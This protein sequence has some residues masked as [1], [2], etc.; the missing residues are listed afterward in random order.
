[1]A[2]LFFL[3]F[4]LKPFAVFAQVS[5]FKNVELETITFG[6]RAS[7]ETLSRES[8]LPKE[9]VSFQSARSTTLSAIGTS[10]LDPLVQFGYPSGATS[11]A[12]GG[13]T[14]DDT[15]VSTLGVPLNLTQG[16]GADLSVLPSYLWSSAEISSTPV[17]QGYTPGAASGA[18]DLKLWTRERVLSGKR[19]R[20]EFD[21]RVTAQYDRQVQTVSVATERPGIA[22]NLGTSLGLQEGPAGSLSYE[23]YEDASQTYR[24]H[25]LGTDQRGASLGSRSNPTPRATKSTWRVIPV[26]ET[27]RRLGEPGHTWLWQSTVFADWNGIR[28]QNPASSGN[29]TSS[30]AFASGIENAISFNSTTIS[31]SLRYE[32]FRLAPN[33]SASAVAAD[34][35][36]FLIGLTQS[37]ELEGGRELKLTG[38]AQGVNTIGVEPALRA[39]LKTHPWTFELGTLAKMPTQSARYYR[40]PGTSPGDPDFFTGN[41]DLKTER[42]WFGIAAHETEAFDSDSQLKSELKLERRERVQITQGAT[43]VNAGGATLGSLE[44]R[45]EIKRWGRFDIHLGL[46][47]NVSRLEQNQN[48]YP[49]LP[50]LA[51]KV[52]VGYQVSSDFA[53]TSRAHYQGP[54][55][56]SG[57][58]FH[59]HYTLIDLEARWAPSTQFNLVG[60]V[61]NITDQRADVVFDFPLPGALA[62]LGVEIQI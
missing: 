31:A 58:R 37:F 50:T 41:P 36:P 44:E 48:P 33:A 55:V 32:Q 21:S 9:Q 16:G 57:G 45:L 56:A 5:E 18:I 19:K 25:L 2:R 39:S 54:S 24:F 49:S 20:P 30:R 38:Q 51:S 62:H 11:T 61:D 42:V 15:Q 52:R 34:E 3:V 17:S 26:L 8:L 27:E 35:F 7:F 4:S 28:F 60:G 23:F 46:A 6:A 43:T 1:M 22:I 40:L 59:P 29:N 12:L 13:R 53:I 47:L 10:V 14:V